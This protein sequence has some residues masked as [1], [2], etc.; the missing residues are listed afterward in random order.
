MGVLLTDVGLMVSSSMESMARA[1]KSEPCGRERVEQTDKLRYD[2]HIH[3]MYPTCI[4][5]QLLHNS[6]LFSKI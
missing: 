6:S 3:S 1:K 5:S 4:L 2:T